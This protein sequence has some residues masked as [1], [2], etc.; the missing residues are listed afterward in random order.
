MMWESRRTHALARCP[1]SVRDHLVANCRSR[2][3]NLSALPRQSHVERQTQAPT[4]ALDSSKFEDDRRLRR[5]LLWRSEAVKSTEM[6]GM[7]RLAQLEGARRRHARVTRKVDLEGCLAR[8]REPLQVEP[9]CGASAPGPRSCSA[10]AGSGHQARDTALDDPRCKQKSSSVGS[11]DQTRSGTRQACRSSSRIGQTGPA[12]PKAAMS[13]RRARAA[14]LQGITSAR[15]VGVGIVELDENR[16]SHAGRRPQIPRVVD[17][18][19]LENG[20]DQRQDCRSASE[21][22]TVA[23]GGTVLL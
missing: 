13:R 2:P 15:L 23:V 3:A 14:A 8:P 18:V 6:V 17:L 22:S 16:A 21:T 19:Q 20:A 7:A 10:S 1:D 11:V 4:T 12:P 9:I 5:L